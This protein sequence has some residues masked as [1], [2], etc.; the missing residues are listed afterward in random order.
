MMAMG[1]G[2]LGLT[3]EEIKSI[4]DD[5]RAASPNI[6]Q[7]WWDVDAAA[8]TTITE[9]CE[10]TTHGL[11]FEY[12]SGI[13]FIT[14]PSGRKLAYVQPAIGENR[15]GGQAITFMGLTMAKKWER[16]ETFGA[17]IAENLTQAVARDILCYAMQNLKDRFICGHVHD[18]MIIEAP[19]GTSL[20]EICD[21]MGQTPPWAKGLPLRADGY[22]TPFYKKD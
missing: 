18:E 11:R 16:V 13:L 8:T 7:F 21:I 1:A 14:L 10:T 19:K 17:K 3:E 12:K 4:V 2:E 6:V 20:Q 15:F 9:R 22:V 5:W